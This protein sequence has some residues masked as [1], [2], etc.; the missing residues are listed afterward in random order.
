[1]ILMYHHVCSADEIPLVQVPLEG[2]NYNIEPA[3][4]E[5]Q[6]R[7]IMARGYQFVTFKTYLAEMA[8]GGRVFSRLA[9]VTFDDGWLDNF[10]NAFPILQRLGIPATFFVVSREMPS[11]AWDRRMTPDQI[12]RLTAS[13]MTIGAHTRSH[14][15]L[16]TLDEYA[17]RDEL[18]GAKLDLE[19]V[20][21]LPVEYLA[22]PGGRFSRK[23]VGAAQDAGYLA[24]CSVINWGQNTEASRFWLYRDVFRDRLD[25]LS[26]KL[27]LNQLTRRIFRGRAKRALQ[28]ML[29]RDV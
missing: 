9:T 16:A 7:A 5:S 8:I 13:G 17:V 21:G 25:G 11:I 1:M 2:W 18:C 12:Q 24:A 4:F 6:L 26:D 22:Y 20:T 3:A 28:K 14:P 10:T 19:Q 15:N 27:R 29:A 23:V